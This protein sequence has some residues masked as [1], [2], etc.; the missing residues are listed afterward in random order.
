MQETTVLFRP[1]DGNELRLIAESGFHAF[2][3]RVPGQPIFYPVLNEE[4]ATQIARDWNAKNSPTKSGYVTRFAIKT[5]YLS[6]FKVHKVGGSYHLEYW[7]PSEKLA[8]FNQNMW[9]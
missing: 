7:I 2:P 6:Q 4:Y 5:E 1:V 3:P 8:D 9:D